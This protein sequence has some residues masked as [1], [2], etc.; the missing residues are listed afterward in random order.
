MTPKNDALDIANNSSKFAEHYCQYKLL[1][2]ECAELFAELHSDF[3]KLHYAV[4]QDD[5][6]QDNDDDREFRER[7]QIIWNDGLEM[8]ERLEALKIVES[9]RKPNSLFS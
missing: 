4:Y 1:L 5:E 8:I 7:L 9:Q 6:I 2:R 3:G